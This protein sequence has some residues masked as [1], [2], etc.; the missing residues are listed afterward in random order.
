MKYGT[1]FFS[2]KAHLRNKE[3]DLPGQLDSRGCCL[4]ALSPIV[5]ENLALKRRREVAVRLTRQLPLFAT[6]SRL[7]P[8]FRFLNV[9]EDSTG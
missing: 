3:T 1:P 7:I 5:P 6:A 4:A 9:L 8:R 2:K